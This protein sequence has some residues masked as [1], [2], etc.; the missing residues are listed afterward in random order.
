MRFK[1]D[2]TCYYYLLLAPYCYDFDNDCTSL[3]MIDCLPYWFDRLLFRLRWSF[4]TVPLRLQ[5]DQTIVL[6]HLLSKPDDDCA[7][8]AANPITSCANMPAIHRSTDRADTH[9]I[10]FRPTDRA[11]TPANQTTTMPLCLQP[12]WMIAPIHL[13]SQPDDDR[14]DMPA[15]HRPTDRAD[16]HTIYHRPNDRAYTPA[17]Y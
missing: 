15:I 13:L 14:T 2:P 9:T 10:Y 7:V 16:T 1:C 17:I 6:I 4:L 3:L 8:M 5:Y 12:D 11:D